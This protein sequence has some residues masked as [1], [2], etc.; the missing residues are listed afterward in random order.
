MSTNKLLLKFALRYP[1]LIIATVV[2]GFSGAL[3]NGIS[4]ALI[5]PLLLGFLG[6]DTGLL[7]KGPAAL[8]AVMR[9]F[10]RFPGDTKFFAMIG[11]VILAIVLKNTAMYFTAIVSNYLSRSL[12]NGMRLEGVKLLLRFDLDYFSKQKIGNIIN[13]VNNEVGRTANA[14]KLGISMFTTLTTVSVFIGI[15]IM[16]S[17]KLTLA[18]AVL[19]VLMFAL[20]QWFIRRAKQYGRILSLKSQEYSNK[21]LEIL[22]GIRLI[23]TVSN[24][25]FEYQKLEQCIREREQAEFASQSN[26]AVIAPINEISGIFTILGIVVI[27]RY[28]FIDQ[29]QSLSTILLIYLVTLFRLLP[30]VGRLNEERSK[31]ANVSPSAEITAHFLREDDKPIMQ[32][33]DRAYTPLQEGIH[34]EGVSFHYPGYAENTLKTVDLWIPQGKTTAL[35]GSSGAGKSTLVD[36]V[37]RFYDP[38]QGRIT[39]DGVDLRDLELRSVRQ[40]MGVVSQ[41]TFLFNNSIRYNIAYGLEEVSDAEIET[42]ARRANAYDFIQNLPQGFETEIGDRGVMLSGGQRQRLAIARALLRDPDILILDEATSALDTVS[43]RLVQDAI[44]ELCR[45]RTTLVIAHRLSTIRQAHQIVV[46]DQGAV[47]EVGTHA[48]LLQRDGH[49]A[50]LHDL[51]FGKKQ[52]K[53]ALPTNAALIRASIRASL[54]L[55]TCLSYEV[56]ARLNAMLGS[57]QLVTDDLVDTP[58][59]RQ[60]LIQESYESALGLL[61]TLSFFEDHGARLDWNGINVAKASELPN[62]SG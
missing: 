25:Q 28:I 54:E 24:E 53:F 60:E 8:Q 26:Y 7:T 18:A 22:T 36:L 57:L 56:R 23:K 47:M 19:L 12:V 9:F 10:E 37:P 59:E 55:R 30:F 17:W 40:A 61:N 51:Q 11:A 33:G 29:L 46:L 45:D 2:L 62:S 27:G 50:K 5:V 52:K 14:V 20:N 48:E 6:Q 43:E 1:F 16:L 3:F 21:L 39:L 32:W 34:F 31:F 38:V 13:T 58:E 4:T 44:D 42:A 15:L 49:Y 41:D 35:V